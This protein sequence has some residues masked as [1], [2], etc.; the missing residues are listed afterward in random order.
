MA[1]ETVQ[2]SVN[3]LAAVVSQA[4]AEYMEEVQSLV[5]TVWVKE[6]APGQI[7]AKFPVWS[8]MSAASALTEGNAAS[9]TNIV[10]TGP[11]LTAT[12][13]AV[14]R[15]LITDLA[16]FTAGG[17]AVRFGRQAAKAIRMK[18][19]QDIYALFDGFSNASGTT[20]TDISEATILSAKH[21]LINRG[22]PGP[23][24]L[25]VTP[26]VYQDLIALYSLNTSIASLDI[27]DAA[28][29]EGRLTPIYGVQPVLVSS[30][31]TEDGNGDYKCAMYS[32]EAIGA[33][34]SWHL[35]TEIQRAAEYVGYNLV[36]SSC[37]AVSEVADNF[38][39][40]IVA[41]GA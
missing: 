1:D 5:D 25:A 4:A 21:A 27:R 41:D 33:A 9:N 19:D 10:S 37:Y 12:T 34:F 14:H 16:D 36:V 2:A 22:A 13:N 28:M 7:S 20:N 17:E 18:L 24:F 6:L 38:G 11:T 31:I 26:R 15:S 32:R 40:E 39:Q 29:K 23:Y 35:K 8:A 30:G 3:E